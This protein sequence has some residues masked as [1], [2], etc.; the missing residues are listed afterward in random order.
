[1]FGKFLLRLE[2]FGNF[3]WHLVHP[4]VYIRQFRQYCQAR[5]RLL[6]YFFWEQKLC[7]SLLLCICRVQPNEN[8][9]CGTEIFSSWKQKHHLEIPFKIQKN[10]FEIERFFYK[11][12]MRKSASRES[13]F[14][15]V[16]ETVIMDFWPS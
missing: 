5:S 4:V 14:F 12:I 6:Y 16:K 11:E 2:N 7:P 10:D 3:W 13:S 8:S 1:M 15:F 9:S